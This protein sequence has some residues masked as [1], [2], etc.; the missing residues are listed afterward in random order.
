[1]IIVEIPGWGE[2]SKLRPMKSYLLPDI[3]CVKSSLKHD[4]STLEQVQN[5]IKF[6]TQSSSKHD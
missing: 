3:F 2:N 1:M 5:S 4:Q 6:K